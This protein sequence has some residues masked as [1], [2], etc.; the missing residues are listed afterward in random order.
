MLDFL[1]KTESVKENYWA[2]LI[3]PNWVTSAVWT[4]E[5]QEAK[6]VTSSSA[7]RWETEEDLEEAVD[8]SLS[9]CSQALPENIIDPSKTVFGLSNLW[10]E[11]GEISQK[12]LQKLKE[13]CQKLSLEPSG[14]VVLSEAI[15]NYYKVDGENL[16]SGITLGISETSLEVSVFEQGKL[17][18]STIVS[19]SLSIV[20]DLIEGLS[21]FSDQL[22]NYPLRIVIYNEKEEELNQIKTE[23]ENGN[24]FEKDNL[25]FIHPPKIEI[26]ESKNKIRS[27]VLAGSSEIGEVKNFVED[28]DVEENISDVS[29][30][31]TPNETNINDFGFEVR[32]EVE[33]KKESYRAKLAKIKLPT[34]KI[35]KFSIVFI[36]II[37]II[38]FL[39]WWFLPKA[40]VIIYV[41]P[42]IITEDVNI[43]F[44]N[45]LT[46]TSVETEVIGEKTKATTGTKVVGE[47]AKGQIKIKN[48]TPDSIRLTSG[49]EVIS[50]NN[51]KFQLLNSASISGALVAG[52][53]GE[54]VIDVEAKS[55]GS[56]YNLLKD[57]VFK[58]SNYPKTDLAGFSL[59]NMTGGSSREIRA[60]SEKDKNELMEELLD[61]LKENAWQGINDEL[62]EKEMAIKSSMKSTFEEI[63]FSNKT[64]DESSI[65]KLSM[66]HKFEVLVVKKQEMIA[67]SQ[68]IMKDKTPDKFVLRDDQIDFIFEDW[69]DKLQNT[70]KVSAKLLP[71][72]DTT[73]I[74]HKIAGKKTNIASSYLSITPGFV[75]AEFR[76]SSFLVGKL[77]TLPNVAGNINIILSSEDE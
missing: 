75:K 37:P 65:I 12:Y 52:T 36:I 18:L 64:G 40:E 77:A 43:D 48:N 29:N 31:V 3:E 46:T 24:L 56:E 44:A 21:R 27:I 5:N 74:A 50:T 38:L 23:L 58:I 54:A 16:F 8:T 11:N 34:I 17:L 69:N 47:K 61:E 30:V 2:L 63:K 66:K 49:T 7:V 28:V 22:S 42:K 71:K 14:F 39:G 51:L 59:E 53:Y 41:S 26:F 19:R 68:K 20:D 1:K 15:I 73:D 55:I 70:V 57:E 33:K 32:P 6:I 67:I 25:K 35:P 4:I 60:V 45:E 62:S 10:I 76:L 72:I 13:I 9:V